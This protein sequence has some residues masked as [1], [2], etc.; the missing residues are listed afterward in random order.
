MHKKDEEE[1]IFTTVLDK[2][3]DVQYGK[4]PRFW[5]DADDFKLLNYDK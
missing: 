5:K 3:L 2:T 4:I 1:D